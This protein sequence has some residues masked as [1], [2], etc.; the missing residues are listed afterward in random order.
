MKDNKPPGLHGSPGL[1]VVTAFTEL[2]GESGFIPFGMLEE[3]VKAKLLPYLKDGRT[4]SLK[5]AISVLNGY[6]VI[7]TTLSKYGEPAY[8]IARRVDTDQFR[9]DYLY[10]LSFINDIA[11]T[12]E[13]SHASFDPLL[14]IEDHV[15]KWLLEDPST[16]NENDPFWTEENAVLARI[17]HIGADEKTPL[18][19][20]KMDLYVSFG[21]SWEGGF[22]GYFSQPPLSRMHVL[23]CRIEGEFERIMGDYMEWDKRSGS[24]E[25]NREDMSKSW[26]RNF[27]YSKLIHWTS[28]AMTAWIGLKTKKYTLEDY[29]TGPV[30]IKEFTLSNRGGY[31]HPDKIMEK[32][33]VV[34]NKTD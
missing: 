28:M 19:H 27:V 18:I 10:L 34:K 15:F 8:R 33:Q 23:F 5:K 30:L 29:N 11:R 31:K 14:F 17:F 32:F 2:I 6:G 16:I 22:R 3:K 12:V 20:R 26:A 13:G 21:N 7:D 4:R 25:G 24:I 1:T 9:F